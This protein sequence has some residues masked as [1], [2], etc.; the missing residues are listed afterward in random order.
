VSSIE[1]SDGELIDGEEDG[2]ELEP[3]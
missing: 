1:E 2:E 3:N